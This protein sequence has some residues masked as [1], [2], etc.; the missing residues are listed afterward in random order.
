MM[1]DTYENVFS[2]EWIAA[3]ITDPIHEWVILCQ[4]IP[5]GTISQR[6]QK[7]YHR[8]KGPMGKPIRMMVA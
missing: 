7:Y 1:Q 4:V 3:N 2:S 6:L 8:S 5:W